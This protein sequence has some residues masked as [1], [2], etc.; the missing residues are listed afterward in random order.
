MGSDL[1][2]FNIG[3]QT[4]DITHNGARLSGLPPLD[5][6]SVIG[7]QYGKDKARYK[8]V[9]IGEVGGKRE[10][11]IGL[12]VVQPGMAQW[13]KILE[14]TPEELRSLDSAFN[15]ATAGKV[16]AW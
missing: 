8:V 3:A 1:K 7:L 9:W 4:L 12:Q 2:P 11:Q 15:A 5:M 10:G 14:A 16:T 6:D 13:Y